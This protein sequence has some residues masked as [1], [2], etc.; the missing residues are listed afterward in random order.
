[1]P[2]TSPI[3]AQSL[4]DT[5]N[6]LDSLDRRYTRDRINLAAQ[7]H[8]LNDMVGQSKSIQQRQRPEVRE[9]PDSNPR[10]HAAMYRH[11]NNETNSTLP[12]NAADVRS[13]ASGSLLRNILVEATSSRREKS[14]RHRIPHD[15]VT[16][17]SRY[18]TFQGSSSSRTTYSSCNT[19][20]AVADARN[21]FP[22]PT[23]DQRADQRI[24]PDLQ[25]IRA[26]DDP[27]SRLP[28]AEARG[29]KAQFVPEP[30]LHNLPFDNTMKSYCDMAKQVGRGPKYNTF[31]KPRTQEANET[32][33]H[34][35]LHAQAATFGKPASTDHLPL[36]F[37]QINS[38]NP[39][40]DSPAKSP[41]RQRGHSSNLASCSVSHAN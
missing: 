3:R 25:K 39:N 19:P 32:D 23:A 22:L 18:G 17:R 28:S 35:V 20:K 2:V 7:E 26:T 31:S 29:V 15:S 40:K 27:R 4:R 41:R 30:A 38:S 13:Y 21:A 11:Q 5:Q 36:E 10:E 1:M 6:R 33:L 12:R 14:S 8:G 34:E 16:D 37:R 24:P 9:Q